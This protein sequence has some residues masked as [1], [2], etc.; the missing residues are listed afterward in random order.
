[1]GM[2]EHFRCSRL[3][4]SR[5]SANIDGQRAPPTVSSSPRLRQLA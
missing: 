4:G 2:T 3:H 5:A 1:L